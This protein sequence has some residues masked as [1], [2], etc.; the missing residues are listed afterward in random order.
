MAEGRGTRSSSNLSTFAD[1][2]L[3]NATVRPRPAESGEACQRFIAHFQRVL[4]IPSFD[5]TWAE[6]NIVSGVLAALCWSELLVSVVPLVEPV[7]RPILVVHGLAHGRNYALLAEDLAGGPFQITSTDLLRVRGLR[8]RRYLDAW[9]RRKGGVP[10]LPQFGQEYLALLSDAI[11]ELAVN[12]RHI[13]TINIPGQTRTSTANTCNSAVGVSAGSGSA[14][15]GVYGT[16]GGVDVATTAAHCLSGATTVT[17]G[18]SLYPVHHVDHVQDTALIDVSGIP[19]PLGLTSVSPLMG[20]SPLGGAT[21]RFEGISTPG[22]KDVV[23][24]WD[25]CVPY[26]P[27]GFPIQAH[28]YTGACTLP[29]DSGAALVDSHNRVVGF[30]QFTIP[31]APV[32]FRHTSTFPGLSGWV[33]AESVFTSLAIK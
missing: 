4:D 24:G 29:G 19:Q 10:E 1:F 27:S 30:A 6:D 26:L 14:S 21:H 25:A 33:W 5:T 15:I 12:W 20:L 13:P 9:N 32:A 23:C 22:G 31:A 28:V 18:G 8:I 2:H 7:R 3:Q 17:L 11:Q 16:S